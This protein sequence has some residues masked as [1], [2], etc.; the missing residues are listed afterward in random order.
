MSQATTPPKRLA[1][2]ERYLTV[3]VFLCMI[4]GTV[5]GKLLPRVT[6]ALSKIGDH[7]FRRGLAGGAGH[8]RRR[9]GRSAGHALDLQ[10]LQPHATMVSSKLA[11]CLK[12]PRATL[13]LVLV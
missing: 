13:L 10:L 2:F 8:G 5:L 3:R 9:A 1:F 11:A 7:A 12:S 6:A 4:A